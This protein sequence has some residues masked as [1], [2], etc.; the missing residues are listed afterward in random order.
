MIEALF[1]N[2]HFIKIGIHLEL[3]KLD[4]EIS[5]AD[6][7]TRAGDGD[8]H[9]RGDNLRKII[10]MMMSVSPPMKEFLYN[11]MTMTSSV[12]GEYNYCKALREFSVKTIDEQK[13]SII[14]AI[15]EDYDNI[16]FDPNWF[17]R[18]KEGDTLK[19]KNFWIEAHKNAN[20]MSGEDIERAY[21]GGNVPE[22]AVGHDTVAVV[23]S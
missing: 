4:K 20:Y 7:R 9:T 22:K 15:T 2:H 21:C 11:H 5:I 10:A 6:E 18:E 13:D 17:N 8:G 16:L 19:D 1:K 3:E 12:F 14:Y 23:L